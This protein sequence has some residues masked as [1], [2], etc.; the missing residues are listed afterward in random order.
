MSQQLA[1]RHPELRSYW[2]VFLGL[3]ALFALA[4]LVAM[5][6]PSFT[7]EVAVVVWGCILLFR[8][9]AEIIGAFLARSS[10]TFMLHLGI[11]VL[12][13]VLGGLIVNHSDEVKTLL[14]LLIALFLFVV[15]LLQVVSALYLRDTGWGWLLTSGL[16]GV[17]VGILV[18]RHVADNSA[19][20]LGM[21][22][23]LDLISR[24]G[25]WIGVGLELKNAPKSSA[26]V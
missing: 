3:G 26:A 1:A 18:W 8:G 9:T 23:G 19:L 15:G 10:R 2:P 5:I 7:A 4:G 20:I 25:T 21:F 22:V 16:V 11:G 24:G 6:I 17:L 14:T 13:L 12:A